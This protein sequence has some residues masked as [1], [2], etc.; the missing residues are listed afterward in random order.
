MPAKEVTFVSLVAAAVAAIVAAFAPLG[1]AMETSMSSG[2][3]TVTRTYGVSTFQ[4]DGAWVLVVVSVPV[5]L[6]ILPNV[7]PR[8]GARI[9]SAVLL[10]ICCVIGAASIGL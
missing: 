10:W 6:T 7:V 4:T 9:V 3:S 1:E 5:L 8:R 2:G